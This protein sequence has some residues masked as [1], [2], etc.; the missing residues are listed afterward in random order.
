MKWTGKMNGRSN[1]I[2]RWTERY[3]FSKMNEWTNAVHNFGGERERE[4]ER[5]KSVNDQYSANVTLKKASSKL[6]RV[7][8]NDS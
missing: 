1:S 2:E 4:R 8:R 7:H 5:P 6:Q 3:A